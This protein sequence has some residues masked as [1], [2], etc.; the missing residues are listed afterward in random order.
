MPD[1][2]KKDV[3]SED[4]VNI[5][6]EKMTQR[7]ARLLR[8]YTENRQHPAPCICFLCLSRK[9]EEDKPVGHPYDLL[10]FLA[11]EIISETED[12]FRDEEIKKIS[13]KKLA[14]EIIRRLPLFSPET[15]AVIKSHAWEFEKHFPTY[16]RRKRYHAPRFLKLVSDLEYLRHKEWQK[17]TKPKGIINL[18][19]K[20][21]TE[22]QL[23]LG[24]ANFVYSKPGRKVTQRDL[25][26][27]LNKRKADIE[28]LQEWLKAVYGIEVRT[29]GRSVVYI[30]TRKVSRN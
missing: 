30:D 24:I 2:P 7:Y 15:K 20:Y 5:I 3:F 21:R 26:R 8:D 6:L 16:S 9:Y 14:K 22:G 23:A 19:K 28:Y 10:T 4:K 1:K 12:P 11:R 17:S 18:N 13:S 27:H 29:E 25:L